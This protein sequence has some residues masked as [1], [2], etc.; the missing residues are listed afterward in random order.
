MT[1]IGTSPRTCVGLFPNGGGIGCD[2]VC[3]TGSGVI[4]V[5]ELK[6]LGLFR[7]L[8]EST[9]LI[10]GSTCSDCWVVVEPVSPNPDRMTETGDIDGFGDATR[11]LL[12][13]GILKGGMF[14]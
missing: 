14:G 5:G 10:V 3:G 13:R 4:E 11:L 9:V 7:P 12:F 2:I 8:F 1:S 6:T